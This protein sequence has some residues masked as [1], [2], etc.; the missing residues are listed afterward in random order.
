MI[1]RS[2]SI[3]AGQWFGINV[4]IHLAFFFLLVFV[5]VME[6]GKADPRS[7]LPASFIFTAIALV[8]VA[9]HE[10]AHLLVARKGLLPR[11][12]VLL[13]I[14]GVWIADVLPEPTTAN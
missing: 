9:L 7:T 4:R 12:I 5:W 2:W 1:M 13:P 10:A 11:A 14:G 6:T 3:P 8:S